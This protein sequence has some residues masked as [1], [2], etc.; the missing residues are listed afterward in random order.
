[1]VRD[2]IQ[3]IISNAISN[4]EL[5]KL[6]FKKSDIDLNGIPLLISEKLCLLQ[7]LEDFHFDGFKIIRIKDIKKVR[8]SEMEKFIEKILKCEN[9]FEIL[10]HNL[11]VIDNW[12]HI[13]DQLKTLGFHI[14]IESEDD[15]FEYFEIGRIISLQ[16]K[17][18]TFQKF[19]VMGKWNSQY[20]DIY[21]KNIVR[22]QYQN[23]YVEV[24]SRYIE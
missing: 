20:K 5:I 10:N 12:A 11:S 4:Q 9:R 1:M 18:V 19:D 3:S 23:E 14:V 16:D 2:D 21:L 15:K 8:S 22:V 6:D 17:V 24:Y 13:L 7:V